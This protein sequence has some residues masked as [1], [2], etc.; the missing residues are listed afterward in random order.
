MKKVRKILYA[1]D[2]PKDRELTLA[3]LEEHNLANEVI[4]VNDGE[5]ALNFLY[6]RGKFS[7]S[8]DEPLAL[9]LLD[10]KMPKID[11]IELLRHIKADE[12]FRLIP[13]VMLTS[14]REEKDLLESYKLGINAYVVK[15]IDFK[16]FVDAVKSIGLFWAILNE[17]I[18]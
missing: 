15:P 7:D 4:C 13:V 16:D 6:K 1:E 5:E 17:T 9:I 10:I 8:Q 11:G 14:S 18:C 12:K 2:N 3:A